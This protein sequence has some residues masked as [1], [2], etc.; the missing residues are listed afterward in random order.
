MDIKQNIKVNISD[1]LFIPV[2]ITQGNWTPPP[3]SIA[4]CSGHFPSTSPKCKST[5]LSL[6]QDM[7]YLHLYECCTSTP[8]ITPHPI[9]KSQQLVWSPS[10]SW[11][12]SLKSIYPW[13]AAT[14]EAAASSSMIFPIFC[15]S[16]LLLLAP[17]PHLSLQLSLPSPNTLP[18][19]T[20]PPNSR[21]CLNP[22]RAPRLHLFYS[23]LPLVLSLSVHLYLPHCFCHYHYLYAGDLSCQSQLLW[24]QAICCMF[25]LQ[26]L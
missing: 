3:L 1:I 16:P 7:E 4:F 19:Q 12:G 6:L 26:E 9:L 25:H 14:R 8:G 11:L 17:K 20:F 24:L 21:I 5:T 18:A 23:S 22:S 2:L 15:A 13:K 10:L